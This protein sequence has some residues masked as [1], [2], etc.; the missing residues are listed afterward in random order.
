MVVVAFSARPTIMASPISL[1]DLSTTRTAMMLARAFNAAAAVRS[2]PFE[3]RTSNTP[4]EDVHRLL[5]GKIKA[6]PEIGFICTRNYN[7][8]YLRPERQIDLFCGAVTRFANRGSFRED[9]IQI[10]RLG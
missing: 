10:C 7:H 4:N 3:P 2:S 6:L 5:Q 1:A 8:S 9:L